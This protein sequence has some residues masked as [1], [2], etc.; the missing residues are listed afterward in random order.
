MN[1]S[2]EDQISGKQNKTIFQE[3]N[4][5]LIFI[6]TQSYSNFEIVIIRI[7]VKVCTNFHKC[8]KKTIYKA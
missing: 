4:K 3:I 8:V 6:M 5:L 2:M 1:S 7:D